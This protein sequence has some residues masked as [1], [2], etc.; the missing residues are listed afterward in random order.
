MLMVEYVCIRNDKKV[1]LLGSIGDIM[2]YM[3]IF[4]KN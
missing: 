3:I 1:I 4:L 2:N